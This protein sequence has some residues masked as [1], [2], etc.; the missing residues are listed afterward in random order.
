MK[1]KL[2][3]DNDDLRSGQRAMMNKIVEVFNY[4]IDITNEVEDGNVTI[5]DLSEEEIK[6]PWKKW[7]ALSELPEIDTDTKTTIKDVAEAY[8]NLLKAIK[9]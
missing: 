9:E 5:A 6:A 7:K 8:N 1:K 4:N 3:F 2:E